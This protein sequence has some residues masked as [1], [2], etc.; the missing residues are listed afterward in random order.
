MS[1]EQQTKPRFIDLVVYLEET[2]ID[3]VDLIKDPRR[4]LIVRIG[5]EDYVDATDA[6]RFE[7]RVIA[8]ARFD[9]SG[10]DLPMARKAA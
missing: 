8:D 4:P 10:I 7:A 5:S 2:G 3:R 1:L 9:R 6:E